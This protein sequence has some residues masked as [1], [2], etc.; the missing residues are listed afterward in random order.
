MEVNSTGSSL[1]AADKARRYKHTTQNTIM[2][3]TVPLPAQ[4]ESRSQHT[5][6][7]DVESYTSDFAIYIL[8][9]TKPHSKVSVNTNK[10]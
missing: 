4:S 2:V 6:K 7:Q 9:T 3:L 10:K 5:Q 1:M 8:S